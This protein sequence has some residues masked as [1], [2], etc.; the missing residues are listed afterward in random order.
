MID[1]QE[2]IDICVANSYDLLTGKK[3]IE[4]ILDSPSQS[5]FLWNVVEE[6]LD[7]KV[8][9]GLMDFMIKYYEEMEYYERCAVL[10][11]IKINER[12]KY[13]QETRKSN[14]VGQ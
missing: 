9:D 3:S 2:I 14:R 8:F 10:L 1:T 7:Q 13:K 6:N 5:Y 12:V 4:Q 11:N